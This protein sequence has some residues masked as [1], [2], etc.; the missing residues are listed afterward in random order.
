MVRKDEATR[1]APRDLGAWGLRLLALGA[2]LLGGC[3]A[4]SART[5][6]FHLD[7]PPEATVFAVD[8]RNFNGSV[9]LRAN[10]RREDV[11]IESRLIVDGKIKDPLRQAL[12]DDVALHAAV[13]EEDGR[14]VLRIAADSPRAE[15]QDHFLDLYVEVPRIDGVMIENRGGDVVVV[16]GSGSTRV[17]NIGGAIEIRTSRPMTEPVTLTNVDGNIYYQVPPGST[18]L[19]DLETLEGECAVKDLVGDTS[20]TYGTRKVQSSKVGSGDNP[21]VCRTNR[22]DIRVWIREDPVALTRVWKKTPPD[23]R[24]QLF[25]KGSRR[26]TRNLPEDHPEVQARRRMEPEDSV[27]H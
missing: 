6:S 16:N 18:G 23:F 21:V 4:P 14:A 5:E 8:I 11:R 2:L 26:Y 12:V 15:R 20:Q 25:L 24:D 3:R 9:E 1:F 22:G 10:S 19:L 13:E 7:V 27:H 17:N